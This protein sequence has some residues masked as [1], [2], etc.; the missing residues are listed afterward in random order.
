MTRYTTLLQDYA[1]HVGLPVQ[2]FLSTQEL[3]IAG[4]AIGLA[5]EGDEDVG[6]V[7]VFSSLGRPAPD[8]EREKLMQL[9]LEANGLW[10][11]TGG[12]TL[13]LQA[14]TGAVLLCVR[15]S[16][17]V[18]D[19]A[20]LSS[21]VQAFVDVALLWQEVVQGKVKPQLPVI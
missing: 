18:S 3:V 21:A 10:V 14:G 15:L 11:G 9:M 13:G 12:C 8:V 20:S 6:N 17:A 1:R 4:I 2:E 5:P 16:L 7:T 19:A